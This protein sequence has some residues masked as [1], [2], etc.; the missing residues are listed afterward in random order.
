MSTLFLVVLLGMWGA[1]FLPIILCILL[2]MSSEALRP[3]I[4]H[5]SKPQLQRSSAVQAA[6]QGQSV[7]ARARHTANTNQQAA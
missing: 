4:V 6:K 5:P 3:E 1:L 2:P 7:P